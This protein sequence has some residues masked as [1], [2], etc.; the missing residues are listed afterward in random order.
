[1]TSRRGFLA[2]GLAI[3]V[4]A[5]APSEPSSYRMENYRAPT[6][7][8]LQGATVLHTDEAHALWVNRQAAFIDVLPRVPRP[9]GLPPGT[10]FRLKPRSDIPGSIWLP[11]TGYGALAPVM[12]GY[13]ERGLDQATAGNHDR[14]VVFYCQ[15]DCWMSWNAAKRAMTLGYHHVGWYPEGTDGWTAHGLATEPREPVPRPD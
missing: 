13:F 1:M 8:T 11:D 6:P 3:L 4:G 9:A 15:K 5:A 2:V 10:I 12:E 14:M 7:D